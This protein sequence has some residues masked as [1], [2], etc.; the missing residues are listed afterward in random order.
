[1]LIHNLRKS[2][3]S[4]AVVKNLLAKAGDPRDTGLIPGWGRFPGG[5]NGNPLRYSCLGNPV[6]RGAWQATVHGAK[7]SD[8]T[9]H[10]HTLAY[11]VVLVSPAQ[12]SASAV[13]GHISPLYFDSLPI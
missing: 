1:M 9:E 13:C 11:S 6:D 4:D 10:A 5:G 8:T 7:D 2:F 3:P 12:P